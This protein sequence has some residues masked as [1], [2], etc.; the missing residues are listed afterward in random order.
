MTAYNELQKAIKIGEAVNYLHNL[1]LVEDY[2][3]V[4]WLAK[5]GEKPLKTN[6]AEALEFIIRINV[7]D[8]EFLS[9]VAK[10]NLENIDK[11]NQ[12]IWEEYGPRKEG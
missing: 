10:I 9:E 11:I 6:L 2:E 1:Y 12:K 5:K 3:Y 8:E 7:V 4:V